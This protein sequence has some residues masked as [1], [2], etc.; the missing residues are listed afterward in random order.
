VKN[1]E[2]GFIRRFG[3]FIVIVLAIFIT[4]IGVYLCVAAPFPPAFGMSRDAWL[5]YYGSFLGGLFGGIATMYAVFRTLKDNSDRD[6]E[7][8]RVSIIPFITVDIQFKEKT[9]NNKID[10]QYYIVYSNVGLGTACNVKIGFTGSVWDSLNSTEQRPIAIPVG[11]PIV[12]PIT[13]EPQVGESTFDIAYSD[14]IQKH[15]YKQQ[16]L[17]T[18][19]KKTFQIKS[20]GRQE[21]VEYE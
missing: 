18:Y 12:Y 7:N 17:M 6:A 2:P 15:K 10:T 11:A 9:I 20:I 3:L 4:P 21:M 13:K 19:D 14:V 16:I 8:M 1:S 5:G